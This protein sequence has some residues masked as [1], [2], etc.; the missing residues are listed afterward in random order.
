[1][2]N[3]FSSSSS[4]AS[5][6]RGLPYSCNVNH[7]PNTVASLIAIRSDNSIPR[8]DRLHS[9]SG[10]WRTTIRSS[11]ACTGDS[12]PSGRCAQLGGSIAVGRSRRF[13]ERN[14]RARPGFI[15][16]DARNAM[17]SLITCRPVRKYQSLR[18][19]KNPDF[20]NFSTRKSFVF[21]FYQQPDW[22]FSTASLDEPTPSTGIAAF[23]K[24]LRH[25]AKPAISGYII[26]YY[27][28]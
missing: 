13:S 23:N 15:R 2:R 10:R 20:S 9:S 17:N 18:L 22:H 4:N 27:A 1:M 19:L 12:A 11:N 24:V 8:A 28:K 3:Y 14:R 5:T 25:V 7:T 16:Y 6:P 21:K 26:E